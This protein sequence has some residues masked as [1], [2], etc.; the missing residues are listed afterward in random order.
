MTD[1]LNIL[2]TKYGALFGAAPASRD[3]LVREESRTLADACQ[4]VESLF[5]T[6]LLGQLRRTL[7]A[8]VKK[9][10]PELETYQN[11]ADQEVARALA[12]G[13]G[14]GL[15]R[16]LYADLG[17]E[18]LPRPQEGTHGTPALSD[19]GG[20]YHGDA[21]VPGAFGLSGT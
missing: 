6:Q 17:G 1:P 7:L 9:R 3:R 13:G 8:G 19:P 15:A 16:R 5:L 4:E 20:D 11:L 12:A 14:L 18:R 21:T 2:A 10:A